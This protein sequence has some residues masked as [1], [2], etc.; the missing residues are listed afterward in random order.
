MRL[1]S[2]LLI[3]FDLLV[4]L[5]GVGTVIRDRGLDQAKRDLQVTR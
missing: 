1:G 2:L 5:G 4:N 3:G